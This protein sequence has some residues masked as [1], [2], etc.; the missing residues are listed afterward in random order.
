MI[1]AVLCAGLLPLAG[2]ASGHDAISAKEFAAARMYDEAVEQ[3]GAGHVSALHECNRL[4]RESTAL[5]PD[6]ALA[7]LTLGHTYR[8][9][10]QWDAAVAAFDAARRC[11]RARA[12]A[13]DAAPPWAA[14]D[15]GLHLGRALIELDRW[16][17]AIIAFEATFTTFP[18]ASEALYRH[19]YL[20]H[21]ACNFTRRG[22]LL[23]LVRE[24]VPWEVQ[25]RGGSAMTP[26]QALMMLN[27]EEL[28]TLSQS[29]A[30]GHLA[31]SNLA[32]APH[33]PWQWALDP[34]LLDVPA[35]QAESRTA[36]FAYSHLHLLDGEAMDG[37]LRV[38]YVSKDWGFSSVG[39]L[40]P[41]L[42]SAHNRRRLQVC[43]MAL[44]LQACAV[45]EWLH[46]CACALQL[47]LARLHTPTRTHAHPHC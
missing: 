46:A 31:A 5:V 23:G 13:V 19:L 11:T 24:R 3:C 25:V 16:D 40:L 6:Q 26:S 35:W 36:H 20:Q 38:G 37:R 10:R 45:C 21:F 8:T 32:A 1:L 33:G 27:G 44:C 42:L 12:G 18:H 17:D 15:A 47:A 34:S 7:F 30:A 9:M 28:R 43:F 29:F 4:L 22:E 2:A 39:Q 41:R 14:E